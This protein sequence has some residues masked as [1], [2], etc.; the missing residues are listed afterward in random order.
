[1]CPVNAISVRHSVMTE[2]HAYS[3]V[4]FYWSFFHSFDSFFSK[5]INNNPPAL[6]SP[7]RNSCPSVLD[8]PKPPQ[9]PELIDTAEGQDRRREEFV[10][11]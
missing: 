1:M 7:H 4:N 2:S 8:F 10:V 9:S 6:T 3:I 11:F 5:R